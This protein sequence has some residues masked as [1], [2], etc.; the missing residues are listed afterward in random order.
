MKR[1]YISILLASFQVIYYLGWVSYNNN[2]DIEI[3][4]KAKTSDTRVL[5]VDNEDFQ[6][7]VL[8]NY[9]YTSIDSL[10]ENDITFQFISTSN[11][12]N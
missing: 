4:D 12:I 6:P 7:A 5:L 2:S 8:E 10:S 11:H 9:T 1:F 3:L